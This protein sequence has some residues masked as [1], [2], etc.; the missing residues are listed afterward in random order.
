MCR[1]QLFY[2]TP[3]SSLSLCLSFSLLASFSSSFFIPLSSSLCCSFCMIFQF[4]YQWPIFS[5]TS[6]LLLPL[7]LLLLTVLLLWVFME[8]PVSRNLR[9][10]TKRGR[11]SLTR[12]PETRFCFAQLLGI[13]RYQEENREFP[14]RVYASLN[15]SLFGFIFRVKSLMSH[16]RRC[17]RR[18]RRHC[19][20][21]RQSRKYSARIHFSKRNAC[22]NNRF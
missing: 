9:E 16:R 13:L 1:V 5:M 3:A 22:S 6:P 4:R 14:T 20:R 8:Q 11:C 12:I 7:S 18:R 2:V 17:C 10:E 19:Y 15:S 21:M